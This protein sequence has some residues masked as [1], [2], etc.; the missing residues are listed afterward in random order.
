[1]RF[2]PAERALFER[3]IDCLPPREVGECALA[4]ARTRSPIANAR[5]TQEELQL[6]LSLYLLSTL[7]VTG[8]I[9]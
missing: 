9:Q 1:M 6:H 5:P 4:C 2:K 7:R 8:P 3:I